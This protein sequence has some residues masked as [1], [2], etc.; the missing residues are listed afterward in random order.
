MPMAESEVRTSFEELAKLQLEIYA[1]E[2]RELYREVRDLR[3]QVAEYEAKASAPNTVLSE[4]APRA[5]DRGSDGT[6]E[7]DVRLSVQVEGRIGLVVSFVQQLRE[8]PAM[9]LRRL[10]N[11]KEDGVTWWV[12]LR[13]P[14]SLLDV[15]G[16]MEGVS[17]V[18][19]D[20]AAARGSEADPVEDEERVLEIDGP[21]L[22]VRL[23]SSNSAA[24]AS[25]IEA[26]AAAS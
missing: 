9:R 22:T 19:P 25:R 7:G 15:L 26:L 1:K 2:V 23:V 8:M 4:S 16:R 3:S 18:A 17:E 14:T 12:A 5:V 6:F 21:R 20:R 11:D 10:S 13:E 24:A